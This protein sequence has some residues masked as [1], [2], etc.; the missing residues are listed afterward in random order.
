MKEYNYRFLES[1]SSP[2]ENISILF[3]SKIKGRDVNYLKNFI[4]S[5]IDTTSTEERD[6]LELI[7]KFDKQDNMK[8]IIDNLGVYVE[9]YDNTGCGELFKLYK[10]L[11]IRSIIYDK[12][13]GRSSIHDFL[14][15]MGTVAH[16]DSVLYFNV[17]DDFLFIR[18][19]WVTDLFNVYKKSVI[20]TGGFCIVGPCST[21]QQ[22]YPTDCKEGNKKYFYN[23]KRDG[24]LL[25][26]DS[27]MMPI[28]KWCKFPDIS[29]QT[30]NNIISRKITIKE[31]KL[32]NYIGEYC[33]IF[34]RKL[35]DVISGN[36]WMASID[37]Y[38]TFLSCI[39]S[40]FYNLNITTRI[41]NFY[42][43]NNFTIDSA[44]AIYAPNPSYNYNT[45]SGGEPHIR[46]LT[47]LFKLIYQQAHNIRL[48][49]DDNPKPLLHISKYEICGMRI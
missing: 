1:K 7:I 31:S 3:S 27:K 18:N 30:I 38:F 12:C 47:R 8:F 26:W 16:P 42:A 9:H 19:N 39:L 21:K 34:S 46:N 44:P 2:K 48:N 32:S 17:A 25:P 13:E 33:P 41:N 35:Y 14:S 40:K 43:R 22:Q 10:G 24:P 29:P 6:R 36:F 5:I 4:K 49:Y 15:Y 20:E 23:E 11:A 28:N 37:A 45:Y